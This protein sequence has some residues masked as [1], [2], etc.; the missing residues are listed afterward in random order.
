MYLCSDA[1]SQQH[2]NMN[3][4]AI[5]VGKMFTL[6]TN[7]LLISDEQLMGMFVQ[8]PQELQKLMLL[9]RSSKF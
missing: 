2:A 6:F 4:V 1:L 8:E 9:Q 7:I 5:L 3:T